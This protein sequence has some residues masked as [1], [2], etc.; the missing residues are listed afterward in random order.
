MSTPEGD[1]AP[2][3]EDA[4]V[5]EGEPTL[6][7]LHIFF[8]F[9]EWV[10]SL[11][12]S[13]IPIL[14]LYM[15]NRD[16]GGRI[17]ALL[18]AA[19]LVLTAAWSVASYLTKRYGLSRVA[20]IVKSGVLRKQ[21]RIIPFGRIQSVNVRQSALQRIFGMAELRVETGTTGASA[22]ADLSVLRWSDAQALREK[23]VA[24]RRSATTG[25]TAHNGNVANS[26][27]TARG[28]SASPLSAGGVAGAAAATAGLAA[29]TATGTGATDTSGLLDSDVEAEVIATIDVE[30]LMVAGGTSNNIGVLIALLVSGC[31][32]FGSSFFESLV[33]PGRLGSPLDA[34]G[35]AMSSVW[36]FGV[37]L[38]VVVLPILFASWL[39]SVAG[40]VVR[41]YGFTLERVGRDLRRRHGLFSRVE[42]SVPVARAQ[43]IRFRQTMLRRPFKRG[44]LLLVSAGSATGSDGSSGGAQHLLPIVHLDNVAR[45]VSEV[46]AD[47]DISD[48]LATG[49]GG[50]AW[51]RAAPLSWLRQAS[52]STL[53]LGLLIGAIVW[54]RGEAW[55]AL[56]WLLPAS[57]ALAVLRWRVRGLHVANGY[58]MV[59]EGGIARTT[60][61]LPER[62][63]QLVELQ[64]GPLQRLFGVATLHFTTAGSGGDASMI[65]LPLA[66][67]RSTQEALASRLPK[68]ARAR[69]TARV[70]QTHDA[71]LAIPSTTELSYHGS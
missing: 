28:S 65:D 8:F 13:V 32:R 1:D 23:L 21:S 4:P 30:E 36:L 56:G 17:V 27:A 68:A 2:T 14:F 15:Q 35:A 38:V 52:A 34:L 71:E 50:G 44:E 57:W 41:Y 62:K 53:F 51:R 46:F 9:L 64:Q 12:R 66:Q 29:T 24:E 19:V 25:S 61:I 18:G 3:A 67:A 5:P 40:S 31:E 59:R 48:V 58:V 37:L 49:S 42:A 69:R 63:L 20:L 16:R 7:R 43:A 10:Q 45:M 55:L 54:W 6:Q 47:A 60:V 22:E 26:A 70:T 33:L 11:T 39:V